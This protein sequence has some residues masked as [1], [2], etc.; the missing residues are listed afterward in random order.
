MS[1]Q[2]HPKTTAIEID[3][4]SVSYG[5]N[6]VLRNVTLIIESGQSVGIFGPNGAGKSTMLKAILGLVPSS[7]GRVQLFG[8][9]V[10]ETRRRVAYVPQRESVDWDFPV[11]VEDVVLMG[12][13]AHLTWLRRPGRADRE[14]AAQALAQVEMTSLARRQI[15]QLSG[16]QQQRV[17][18]ARALAQD[19]DIYMLDEP[20][21]GVDA[22]TEQKIFEIMKSLRAAG[23]LVLV[24]NHDLNTAPQ[25]DRLLF[26]NGRLIAYGSVEQVFKPAILQRAYGGRLTL[27]QEADRLVALP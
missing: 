7:D 20:F 11:L 27:L 1:A 12:R 25:F 19:A 4:L 10:G 15:G 17:F 24:V 5:T 14:R 22:A 2:Q 26:L 6:R 3:N 9:A 21:I 18:L 8:S 13:Y 23:K 16:G